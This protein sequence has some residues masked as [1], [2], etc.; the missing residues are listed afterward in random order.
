MQTSS[1]NQTCKTVKPPQEGS[2]E[3]FSAKVLWSSFK[4]FL[5]GNGWGV[6]RELVGLAEVVA[7]ARHG[8]SRKDIAAFTVQN[9][10]KTWN[11]VLYV[12]NSFVKVVVEIPKDPTVIEKK[13]VSSWV[14]PLEI[15]CY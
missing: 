2:P 15:T 10:K 4:K 5:E 11:V 6:D 1:L 14:E 7:G 8:I 9:Y 12:K 3:G 13:G